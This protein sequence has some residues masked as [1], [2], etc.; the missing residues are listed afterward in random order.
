MKNKPGISLTLIATAA[1]SLLSKIA[2]ADDTQTAGYAVQKTI[3]L[4]GNERWDE[5]FFSPSLHRLLV[6]RSTHT[7]EIDPDAGKVVADI[8]GPLRA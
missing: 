6:T 8:P 1:L 4:P 2:S 3:P 7:Q 5:A